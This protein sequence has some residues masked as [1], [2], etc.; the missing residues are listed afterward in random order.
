MKYGVIDITST[1]VSLKIYEAEPLKSVFSYRAAFSAQSFT[2][3]GALTVHGVQKIISILKRMQ[4]ECVKHG[5]KSLYAISASV[6]RSIKNADEV[7]AQILEA[8]GI[9]INR[10]DMSTEAYCDYVSNS[11][12]Y[13]GGCVLLD[14]SGGSIAVCDMAATGDGYRLCLPFGA[15]QLQKKFVKGVFP[16]EDEYGDIKKYLKKKFEKY[17]V[18]E[19][20]TKSV[21]L[22]G[23]LSRSLCAI[24][25]DE[26][27]DDTPPSSLEAE[28]LKNLL[29]KLIRDDDRMYLVIKNAPEKIYFITVALIII[30][31]L[32]KRFSPDEVLVSENGVKEGYLILNLKGELNGAP[33]P[34]QKKRENVKIST[35]EEL[36]EH[37]KIRSK[38]AAKRA[39]AKK[40]TVRKSAAQKTTAKKTTVKKT[41]AKKTVTTEK[42]KKTATGGKK[43]KGAQDGAK[44]D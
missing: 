21:I 14:V 41:T 20:K 39:G 18:P 37:I 44:E 36:E 4:E 13:G 31:Q 42:N 9:T 12:S 32:V 6:T 11:S 27:C 28:K 22:T 23:N 1:S 34:A 2:V 24:Y 8:T 15:L 5:A 19:T 38:S 3:G 40:P 29:K 7:S 35:V 16:T 43:D 25:A 26:Y 10:L 30:M 33:S 17:G